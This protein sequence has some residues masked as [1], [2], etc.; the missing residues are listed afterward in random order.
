RLSQL[1][2]IEASRPACGL[3]EELAAGVGIC[4]LK[5]RSAVEL[6]LVRGDELPVAGVGQ[7]RLPERGAVDELRRLVETLL[8]IGQPPI[9]QAREH[10]D[11]EVDVPRL[12]RERDE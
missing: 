4:S 12:A 2:R 8:V 3:D 9:R 7:R 6:L 5:R 1:L 11:V 10:L